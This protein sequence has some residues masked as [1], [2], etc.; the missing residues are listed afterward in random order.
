MSPDVL[1]L[2][3]RVLRVHTPSTA[4]QLYHLPL[5]KLW[6]A[7]FNRGKSN[8]LSARS[9]NLADKNNRNLE[10]T[11]LDLLDYRPTSP[12]FSLVGLDRYYS[13]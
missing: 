1:L 7:K 4:L 2:N 3:L 13:L 12:N 8:R 10:S 11:L 6:R 5:Q 9:N